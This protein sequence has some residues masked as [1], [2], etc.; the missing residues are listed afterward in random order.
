MAIWGIQKYLHW[1]FLWDPWLESVFTTMPASASIYFCTKII[2]LSSIESHLTYLELSTLRQSFNY[3]SKA[4][5]I[6]PTEYGK[7]LPTFLRPFLALKK[8]LL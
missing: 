2:I 5:E 6:P 3:S 1:V 8:Q 4:T 7:K